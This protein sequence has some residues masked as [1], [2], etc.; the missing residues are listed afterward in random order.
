MP[1]IDSMGLCTVTELIRF[2]VA[3]RGCDEHEAAELVASVLHADPA[4]LPRR[5]HVPTEARLRVQA[6][7]AGA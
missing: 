5:H 3:R 4:A 6:L 7:V 2:V 1:I